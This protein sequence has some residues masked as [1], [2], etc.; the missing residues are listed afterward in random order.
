MIYNDKMEEG[1]KGLLTEFYYSIADLDFKVTRPA[2]SWAYSTKKRRYKKELIKDF[3]LKL[4]EIRRLKS[5][6]ET[7]YKAT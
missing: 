7:L 3:R 2:E 1:T 4:K 6:E 5:L